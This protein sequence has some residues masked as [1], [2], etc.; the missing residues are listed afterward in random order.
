MKFTQRLSLC[1]D[2]TPTETMEQREVYSLSFGLSLSA[3]SLC[4]MQQNIHTSIKKKWANAF[5]SVLAFT[6]ERFTFY[7]FV[8]PSIYLFYSLLDIGCGIC[9]SN[10]LETVIF[11]Y[12]YVAYFCLNCNML[13]SRIHRKSIPPPPILPT[14]SLLKK[15]IFNISWI[16]I[17][18]Q[19]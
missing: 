7:S 19:Q 13:T 8:S 12:S 11:L 5:P 18:N 14:L 3:F 17:H 6:K 4:F 10:N 9:K 15:L 16:E 2:K 1:L